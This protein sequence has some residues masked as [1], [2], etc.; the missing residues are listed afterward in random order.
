MYF[1]LVQ[2]YNYITK[3]IKSVN[4]K[5]LITEKSITSFFLLMRDLL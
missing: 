4:A 3:T 1:S 2:L 5:I